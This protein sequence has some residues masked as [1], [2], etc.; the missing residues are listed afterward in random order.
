MY[1]F[2]MLI[3]VQFIHAVSVFKAAFFHNPSAPATCDVLGDK[4]PASKVVVYKDQHNIQVSLAPT[5][6]HWLLQSILLSVYCSGAVPED[7]QVHL[8]ID[9]NLTSFS[10]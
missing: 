2:S 7:N 8:S 1:F 3:W 6:Y 9:L 4:L 10:I 5:L